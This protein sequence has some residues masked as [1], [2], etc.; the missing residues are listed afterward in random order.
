[1]PSIPSGSLATDAT[2]SQQGGRSKK[3]QHAMI[4]ESLASSRASKAKKPKLDRDPPRLAV[5]ANSIQSASYALE[6]MSASHGARVHCIC[7]LLKDDE[8]T[9]WYY[10]A[11]G[12]V[13]ASDSI[14]MIYDFQKYAAFIVAMGSLTP[15]QHGSLPSSA[16]TS[17]ASPAIW[18][19][20]DVAPAFPWPDLMGCRIAMFE[21]E[22]MPKHTLRTETLGE[23]IISQY[24]LFGRRTSVYGAELHRSGK[25]RKV[26][27]KLSYQPSERPK[28][29]AFVVR[30]CRAKVPHV[31][32]IEMSADLFKMSDGIRDAFLDSTG[33][34]VPYECRTLRA[35]MYPR[36]R[37]LKDLFT[38]HCLFI[39]VMADQMIVCARYFLYITGG[40][41]TTDYT[42]V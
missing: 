40:L 19:P 10:D 8:I 28:E 13:H 42:Q 26:V 27:V 29:Q 36:Y 6:L 37:P 16:P 34:V 20:N 9:P 30:A 35:I 18:R 5:D 4:S 14:S 32:R 21:D 22:Q 12:A 7:H 41:L 25:V 39:P 31:P 23:H 3:R 15:E 17:A 24:T 2:R 33:E 11:S 1:M 38:D